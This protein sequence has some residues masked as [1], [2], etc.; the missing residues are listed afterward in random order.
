MRVPY[1][2]VGPQKIESDLPDDKVL[3]LSDILPTGGWLPKMP[4]SNLAIPWR[5]GAADRWRRWRFKVRG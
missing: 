3:F 5:Y 2:D 1:A 4:E